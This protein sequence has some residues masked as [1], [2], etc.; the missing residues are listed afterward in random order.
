MGMPMKEAIRLMLNKAT[1]ICT[2]GRNFSSHYCFPKWNV[3]PVTS[4]IEVQYSAAIGTARVQQRR[5]TKGITIVTGGD[6]GS[7]EGDFATSLVWASRKGNELP[8]LLTVHNTRWGISTSYEG[9]HGEQ[10]ISD[11]GKPFGMKTEHFNGNDPIEAYLVLERAMKY[12]REKRRPVLLEAEVSRLYGHSSA[13]GA[14]REKDQPCC[15]ELFEK[16]LQ[17][18]KILSAKDIKDI[19]STHEKKAK[20]WAN[21]V[22]KEADPV[23]E[24]IWQHFYSNG[25]NG[26]WR[27]F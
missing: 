1:D 22:R 16:R 21:E 14:N 9:Q 7:A 23:P 5:Q 17:K 8:M 12:V 11:R 13:S 25:E 4:P 6:A 10:Y 18:E 27:K 15:I 26:D 3:V 2:G 20:E 19:W 24:A